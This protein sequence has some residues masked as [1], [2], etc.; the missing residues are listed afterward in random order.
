MKYVSPVCEVLEL[1]VA[2]VIVTSDVVI[3]TPNPY[4]TPTV[5]VGG[6][7][8]DNGNVQVGQ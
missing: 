7:G 1:S 5:P 4:D 2:D 6:G 8:T 3:E